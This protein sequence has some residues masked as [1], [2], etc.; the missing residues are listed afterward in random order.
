MVAMCVYI[1]IAVY[2]YVYCAKRVIGLK[3]LKKKK[4]NNRLKKHRLRVIVNIAANDAS[5][6]ARAQ[7]LEVY[8]CVATYLRLHALETRLRSQNECI[9][10]CTVS[11]K[12]T[13][14]TK[15]VALSHLCPR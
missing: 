2:E 6:N 1:H 15:I 11:E 4:E 7:L 14:Q 3:S 9:H 10:D 13:Q 8:V 5:S 12:Y